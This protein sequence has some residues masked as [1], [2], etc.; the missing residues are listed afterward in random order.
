MATGWGRNT[1]SSGPW[2]EGDVITLVTGAATLSGVAPSLVRSTVIIPG[3][4]ALALQVICTH[5]IRGC[6]DNSWCRSASISW[7]CTK[8]SMK[9][10]VITPSVGAVLLAGIAPSTIED[11]RIIPSV[12][13]VTLAGT[14]PDLIYGSI[15]LAPA[16]TVTLAGY[17]P[18]VIQQNNVFVTPLVG[19]V[20]LAGYAPSIYGSTVITPGVGAVTITGITA[21][22]TEGAVIR[23]SAGALALQGYVPTN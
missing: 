3:V 9:V 19:A 5:S 7:T 4:G 10:R 21:V 6:S 13:T 17:A 14:A 22:R 2:G 18:Q 11:A 23:P 8:F 12:G 20:S 16:G 1:W 15:I